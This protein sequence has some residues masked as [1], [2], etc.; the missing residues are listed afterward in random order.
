LSK[1]ERSTT[2]KNPAAQ[3]DGSIAAG[4]FLNQLG[5]GKRKAEETI[6]NDDVV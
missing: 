6:N 4:V 1:D 2:I 3:G 5:R